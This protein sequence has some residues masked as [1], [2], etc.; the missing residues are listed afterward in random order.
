MDGLDVVE[1]AEGL[2][3]SREHRCRASWI[4][5]RALDFQVGVDDVEWRMGGQVQ[6]G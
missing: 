1:A 4:A 5:D 2:G 6:D 3:R